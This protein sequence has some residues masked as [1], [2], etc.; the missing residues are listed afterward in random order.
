MGD[1][2]GRVEDARFL[3]GSGHYVEDVV[4]PGCRH[5]VFVRSPVAHARITRIDAEPVRSSSSGVAIYTGRDLIAAGVGPMVCTRPIDSHDG[6]P[7]RAPRRD[8]LATDEIRFVGDPVIMVVAESIERALDAAERIDLDFEELAVVCDP[9]RSDEVAAIRKLGDVKATAR[10]FERAAHVVRLQTGNNR[11][12]ALPLETRSALGRFDSTQGTYTLETQTQGVHLM[13]TLVADSLGVDPSRLR[14]VTPDVGGSFGMKLVSYPE[15]IAVLVA[16]RLLGTPVRWVSTRNEAMLSDTHARDHESLAELALDA[17][18]NILALRACT[19][20]NMGAYA[21]ALATSSPLVGFGRTIG[22]V[23]RIPTLDCTSRAAYTHT[24]PT[25]AFR[26]AGK[27]ESV[28]LMERLLDEAAMQLGM[29]RMRLRERNL[30]TA[31][32][33]PYRAAN[34]ETWDC[35]DFP[36][37]LATALSE[38]NWDGFEGRRAESRASGRLRGFGLGLY[39]HMAGATTTEISRVELAEDGRVLV[40]VGAQNLGQGHE[41]TF[42]ELLG[43]HLG[44]SPERITVV[45]G[46][47][48]RLPPSGAASGGSSSLQCAG[49]TLLRA[50]DSL[51]ERLLPHAAEQLEVATRDVVYLQGQFTVPGTDLVVALDT[52][53][54]SV[55]PVAPNDCSATANF[56]GNVVSVPNGAYTCEVEVD[57]DTG[58]VTLCRYVAVDDVGRR[59]NP[60]VVEGQLHGSIAHGLG[61]AMME[62]VQYDQS[63]QLLT[64]SLMDYAALRADDVC[65]FELHAADVLTT[66]NPIGAKGVGEL[67]C[68]GAPGALMNAVADAIGTQSVEMPA[69]PERVW[70]ALRENGSNRDG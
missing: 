18:G 45:Q 7:F 50:A 55:H 32:E 42:A 52:L 62:H 67:G 66:N 16:A 19:H 6:T 21:S 36:R 47:T 54:R 46:D 10:A 58:V 13:R 49:P 3:R 1:P 23:Y 37:V 40:Y 12:V 8:V 11:V 30:V 56:E 41:T 27:P 26:G 2:V 48:A 9:A 24:A 17:D 64:G 63:G 34:G 5:A 4:R 28:H 15:Q 14:V 68:L 35:G 22:N 39:L 29:D 43:E 65:N 44:V 33:M 59:I 57:P 20:G 69:T 31:R 61:Q 60:T 25:D 38:S 70:R 53:A 51:V